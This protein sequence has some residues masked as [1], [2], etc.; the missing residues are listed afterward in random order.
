M[1][2]KSS[3]IAFI[4][5][6]MA[7]AFF[8]VKRRPLGRLFISIAFSIRNIT[9][10]VA[11]HYFLWPQACRP[12]WW[13]WRPAWQSQRGSGLSPCGQVSRVVYPVLHPVQQGAERFAIAFTALVHSS[14]HR[15]GCHGFHVRFQKDGR[16]SFSISYRLSSL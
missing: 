8:H 13:V 3:K 9:A 7:E 5:N 14:E 12:E 10:P 15:C 2:T 11:W 1:V 4:Y 6:N 16:P